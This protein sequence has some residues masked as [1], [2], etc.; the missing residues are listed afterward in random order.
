MTRAAG[1]A[2]ERNHPEKRMLLFSRASYVGMHRYGGIWTGDNHAWWEHL[3]QNIKMMPSLNMCG[4]LYSGADVGGFGGHANGEL[5]ARWSQ[6][7][8]YT[9]L[10]RNHAC[11]GTRHQ[12]P[13]SFEDET[14]QITRDVI[15]FRY[16]FVSHLYS[17][18][19]KARANNTLLFRPLS[20]DFEDTHAV[21]V[22]NQ[23]M[24]GESLMLAPIDTQNAEGRYVYLPE[25]MLQWRIRSNEDYDLEYIHQGHHYVTAHLNE[26]LNYIKENSL[27]ALNEVKNNVE[28]IQLDEL[29]VIGY[30]KDEASYTLY[31]DDG[32]SRKPVGEYFELKVTYDGALV[33]DHQGDIGLKKVVYD[34]VTSD[35]KRH[36]GVYHV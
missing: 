10:F 18:F 4:F 20:F 31:H 34:I 7:A 3:Q 30:V 19:M 12:E 35:N 16:A 9:P 26:W 29:K 21:K 22:E 17:E 8:V 33:F 15:R 28:E 25:D 36:K 27:I 2:F 1:E 14:T 23:L 13:F 11:M 6:F 24:F 5:V 32:I